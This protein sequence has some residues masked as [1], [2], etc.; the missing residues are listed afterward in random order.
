MISNSAYHANRTHLSSSN[1]KMV[2]EDLPEFNRRWNLGQYPVEEKKSYFQDGSYTHALLLEP[3]KVVEEFAFYEGMRK[4]GKAFQDFSDLHLGKEILS[5]PQ[6]LRAESYVAAV[7]RVPAALKLLEGCQCE[8]PLTG[9]I[10][11][12]DVKI[13]PDAINVN[14]RYLFDLKTTADPAGLEIFKETVKRYKYDLSAAL[15]CDVAVQNY[16]GLDFD[17]YWIVV[18][19]SDLVCDIYKASQDT[20]VEGRGLVMTALARYKAAKETGNWEGFARQEQVIN[21]YQIQEI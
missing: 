14:S 9:S 7:R 12:V 15:Y 17:Y 6:K 4:Q 8:V 18:S 16:P 19:K 3:H 11:G 2:L 10:A 21:G 13:R 20:L 1:L 5:M